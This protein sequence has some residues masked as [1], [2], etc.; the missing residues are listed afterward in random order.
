M[1]V[2]DQ[3]A[4]AQPGQTRLKLGANTFEIPHQGIRAHDSLHID[5][6]NQRLGNPDVP[7]L[8]RLR[9]L[10]PKTPDNGPMGAHLAMGDHRA[11]DIDHGS[12]R[13]Q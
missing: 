6:R 7:G 12:G 10:F 2:Y 8:G 3:P 1:I 13:H 9:T 4:N 11:Q 5:I